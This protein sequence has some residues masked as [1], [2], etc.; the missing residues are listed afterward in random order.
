MNLKT[1][2]I[3]LEAVTLKSGESYFAGPREMPTQG[4]TLGL[5]TLRNASYVLVIANGTHK[6][7][8]VDKMLN[9]PWTIDL[10]ASL[11]QD[12]ADCTLYLDRAASGNLH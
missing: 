2:V 1:Q 6:A 5:A 3:D 10:P 11:L 8:V 9:G 7:A 12:H 4:I